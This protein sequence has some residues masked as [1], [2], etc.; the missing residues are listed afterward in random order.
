M[1]GKFLLKVTDTYFRMTAYLTGPLNPKRKGGV[2]FFFEGDFVVTQATKLHQGVSSV[3]L[4][5]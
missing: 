4:A 2:F 5:G 1:R 3:K